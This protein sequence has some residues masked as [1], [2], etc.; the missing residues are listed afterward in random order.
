MRVST[1]SSL[2]ILVV[3]DN[4]DTTL[5]LAFLFRSWGHEVHAVHDGPSA[6]TAAR[7]FLPQA[8]ILDIGLPGMDGF[9]VAQ[10]LRALPELGR[11]LLV[12]SSGYG[13]A[14]DR[15]RAAEVGI[16]FYLVK[17]FDPW[18]LE[19]LLAAQRPSAAVPTACRGRAI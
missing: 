9:E 15:K 1:G 18:K 3:D 8:V 10:Q 5:G 7:T 19:H 4:E 17:P 16:D 14:R 11:V 12:G 6:I 2:R 13:H